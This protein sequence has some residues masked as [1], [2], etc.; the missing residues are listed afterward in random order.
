MALRYSLSASGNFKK[1]SYKM[2]YREYDGIFFEFGILV[3]PDQFEGV[4]FLKRGY[5]IE[6]Y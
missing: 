2:V 4:S 3:A 1:I 5:L 6:F